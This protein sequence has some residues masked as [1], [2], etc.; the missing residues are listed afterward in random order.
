M[1]PSSGRQAGPVVPARADVP[2][3]ASAPTPNAAAS[4]PCAPTVTPSD[5]ARLAGMSDEAL[6]AKTGGGWEKSVHSL[7]RVNAAAWPHR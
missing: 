6:K 2:P 5:Y 4:A 1:P 3:A 7:D